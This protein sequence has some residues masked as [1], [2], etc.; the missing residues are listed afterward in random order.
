MTPAAA[1][2]LSFAFSVL[3][4]LKIYV[5]V[6]GFTSEKGGCASIRYCAT[7]GNNTVAIIATLHTEIYIDSLQQRCLQHYV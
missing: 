3:S 5:F 7:I 2:L 1:V 4:L 6:Y